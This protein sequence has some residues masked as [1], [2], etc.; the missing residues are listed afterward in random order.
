MK[1]PIRSNK[2]THWA[3]S[4]GLTIELGFADG[5]YLPR[6]AG[7]LLYPEYFDENGEPKIEMLP[8]AD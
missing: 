3:L 6:K 1:K 7:L 4:W 5:K 2:P 8:L